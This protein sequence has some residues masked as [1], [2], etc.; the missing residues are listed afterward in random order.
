MSDPFDL[1]V[2]DSTAQPDIILLT[3]SGKPKR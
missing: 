2:L 3:M 1:A